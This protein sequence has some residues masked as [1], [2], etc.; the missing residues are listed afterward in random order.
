MLH[1]NSTIPEKFAL[2]Y[3]KGKLSQVD[4]RRSI[5][6]RRLKKMLSS[7]LIHLWLFDHAFL[8]SSLP[9]YCLIH[10]ELL[11]FPPCPKFTSGRH[12]ES[13]SV[14]LE[15]IK[16]TFSTFGSDTRTCQPVTVSQFKLLHCRENQLIWNCSL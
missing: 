8:N 3:V 14:Q 15:N 12:V 10:P 6:P 11:L 5:H 2:L 1:S 7:S 9:S 4:M 13:G 16:L